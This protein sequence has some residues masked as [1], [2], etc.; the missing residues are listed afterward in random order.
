MWHGL[1]KLLAGEENKKYLFHWWSC[2]NSLLWEDA[3]YHLQKDQLHSGWILCTSECVH[4]PGCNYSLRVECNERPWI[5]E[6]TKNP[7]REATTLRAAL[8]EMLR[9]AR[10]AY[11]PDA[12]TSHYP[13]RI[14]NNTLLP[15][16]KQ[17]LSDQMSKQSKKLGRMDLTTITLRRYAMRVKKD[18]MI[19]SL[20]S[21]KMRTKQENGIMHGQRRGAKRWVKVIE[22]GGKSDDGW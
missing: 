6:K 17:R 9:D 7:L 8:T 3:W 1:G 2:Q 19:M 5:S 12:V 21:W 15:K 10:D 22:Q 20:R 13:E 4:V 14:L 11:V 16:E 18:D